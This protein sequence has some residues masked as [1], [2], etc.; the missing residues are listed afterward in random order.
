M[1]GPNLSTTRPI[2]QDLGRPDPPLAEDIDNMK[3]NKLAT[4]E[5]AGPHASLGPAGPP[6]SPAKMGNSTEP[7][8]AAA[9]PQNTASRRAPN[10]PGTPCNPG[11]PRTPENSLIVTNPSST[12]SNSAKTARRPD[13]TAVDIPPAC[14]PPLSH[15]VVQGEPPPPG[16]SFS[17]GT[18]GMMA[19]VPGAAGGP[20]GMDAHGAWQGARW[21]SASEGPPGRPGRHP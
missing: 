9:T 18:V 17:L 16:L 6:P 13:H 3:N 7:G 12:Q 11:P 21:P 5:A 1:P 10:N 20:A 4:A 14:P 8:V 2:Q 15:T 19:P